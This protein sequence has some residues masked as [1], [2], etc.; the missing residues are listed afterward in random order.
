M[1]TLNALFRFV[2][3][4]AKI[5]TSTKKGNKN[6]RTLPLR[7]LNISWRLTPTLIVLVALAILTPWSAQASTL[8]TIDVPGADSTA[9]QGINASG[10]IVG[11][12]SDATS[13]HGFQFTSGAFLTVDVPGAISTG[14]RGINSGGDIV[15]EYNL[16]GIT[17]HGFLRSGNNFT[18]IDFPGAVNTYPNAINAFGKIVG[19]YNDTPN[20]LNSHGFLLDKHGVFTVIDYPGATSTAAY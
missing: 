20:S 11:F 10:D 19:F 9:A 1:S 2:R 17:D 7:K 14:P 13:S 16:D 18:T 8:T 6:M 4:K 3:W 12:W 5:P 15:G